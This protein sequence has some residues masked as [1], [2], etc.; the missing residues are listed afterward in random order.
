MLLCVSK[1]LTRRRRRRRSD[2]VDMFN[3][4]EKLIVSQAARV[5][6]LKK[7]LAEA[8][9]ELAASRDILRR[10]EMEKPAPTPANPPKR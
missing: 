3:N 9:A 2:T 4:Y 7:T 8:E 5:E 1:L 10:I 6:R